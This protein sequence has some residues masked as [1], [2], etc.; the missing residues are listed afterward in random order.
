MTIAAGWRLPEL[1]CGKYCRQRSHSAQAEGRLSCSP[2]RPK[3][4][5]QSVADTCCRHSDE[6][7]TGLDK[8]GRAATST[9]ESIEVG[10]A[11]AT[12]ERNHQDLAGMDQVGIPDAVAV[13]P[14][15]DRVLLARSI[16]DAADAPEAVAPIDDPG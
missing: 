16:G 14:I 12:P 4:A 1:W 9:L 7:K 8:S 5:A 10:S 2:L 13:G 11:S 15:D 3:Q 6:G